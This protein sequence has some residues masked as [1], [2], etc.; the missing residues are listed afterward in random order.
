LCYLRKSL[1]KAGGAEPASPALQREL[2]GKAAATL[3]LRAEYHEDATGHSSGHTQD[4]PGWQ[5]LAARLGQGDVAALIVHTWDRAARNTKHLLQIADDCEAAGVRFVSVSDNIDTRTASGRFQL[6]IIAGVGEYESNASSERRIATIDYLRRAK[7]RHYGT[8]PFGTERVAQGGDLVLVPSS[9]QQA[10]GTDAEALARAYTL[11]GGG[12]LSLRRVCLQLNAEGWRWRMRGDTLTPWSAE[13]LR[14]VLANHMLYAGYVPVGRAYRGKGIEYL[15]GSHAPILPESLLA[16]VAG[17]FATYQRGPTR[18]LPMVYP[19]TGLLYCGHCGQK[20]SG[21]AA[22]GY[23]SYKHGLSCGEQNSYS[24]LRIETEIKD[25]IASRQFPADLQAEAHLRTLDYLA[26]EQVTDSAEQRRVAA[27]LDRLR[28]LYTWGDIDAD[29]YRKEQAAIRASLPAPTVSAVP[30]DAGVTLVT[31][32][33]T[34]HDY[35]PAQFMAAV[36]LLYTRID[37]RK[38]EL[39]YTARGW[40]KEWA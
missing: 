8:A 3:G 31:L 34:A 2:T 24:G 4:R 15:K 20:L 16:P 19:L 9:K 25:H 27:A 13:A 14:R 18:K 33:A 29:T 32:A 30:A 37:V 12:R 22:R 21:G 17:M 7:G 1:V 39:T 23:R 6:T 38:W 5:A 11:Y 10:N 26:G 28:N 36:R 35:S 40:C